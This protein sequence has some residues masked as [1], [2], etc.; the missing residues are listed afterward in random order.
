MSCSL[1]ACPQADGQVPCQGPFALCPPAD[2]AQPQRASLSH[3]PPS[4][5]LSF[6][7]GPR[8]CPHLIPATRW[9]GGGL[10]GFWLCSD[11][12][13]G[14][15]SWTPDLSGLVGRVTGAMLGWQSWREGDDRPALVP[16]GLL[17]LPWP[18]SSTASPNTT[19]SPS[20]GLA[21]QAR[22]PHPSTGSAVGNFL[23]SPLAQRINKCTPHPHPPTPS[24][25]ILSHRLDLG[26]EP[27]P[28]LLSVTAETSDAV[29]HH[30]GPC[31]PA[32]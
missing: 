11:Q 32:S 25:L 16:G 19:S 13:L 4:L 5:S 26:N 12:S 7:V 28:F 20:P 18:L 27:G 14:H 3:P 31:H 6:V 24:P 21:G 2:R 1:N 9:G 23:V 10:P 30:R 29:S 8:T 22:A 17:G 15:P